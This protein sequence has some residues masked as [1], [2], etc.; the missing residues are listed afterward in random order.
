MVHYFYSVFWLVS[1]SF[2]L[3]LSTHNQC[4]LFGHLKLPRVADSLI[5][6]HC[7]HLSKGLL[8]IVNI[9][10][11]NQYFLFKKLFCA[12]HEPGLLSNGK[13][14]D[15]RIQ[16][17]FKV[18]GRERRKCMTVHVSVWNFSNSWADTHKMVRNLIQKP[19]ETA[20]DK[21]KMRP[22]RN[23]KHERWDVRRRQ[24]VWTK[25]S[26]KR[27]RELTGRNRWYPV[28]INIYHL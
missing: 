1:K 21:P 17:I 9:Q 15:S 26:V 23:P 8:Y 22:P 10:Q 16:E 25:P 28:K 3:Y 11:T 20:Q 24:P 12:C 2:I 14:G 27:R 13:D 5:F 19:G 18:N 7:Q 4:I 6:I